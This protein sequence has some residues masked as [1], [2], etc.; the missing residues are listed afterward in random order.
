MT[1]E[2]ASRRGDWQPLRRPRLIR[3]VQTGK[4]P[5]ANEKF[6]IQ[7]RLVSLLAA[8]ICVLLTGPA[9]GGTAV[10]GPTPAPVAD[11]ASPI[12]GFYVSSAGRLGLLIG[13]VVAL[14]VWSLGYSARFCQTHRAAAA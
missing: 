13:F 1:G 14:A 5:S 7:R 3:T 11:P 9:R 6:M 10:G 8:S 2:S 12:V 4:R